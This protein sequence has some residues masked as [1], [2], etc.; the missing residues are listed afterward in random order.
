MGSWIV[1]LV[2]LSLMGSVFWVM[3]STRDRLRMRL[4]Q[5]A[6]AMGLKV[7]LPDQSL[8][9]RLIRYEDLI[10]GSMMYECLNFSHQAVKFSGGLYVLKGQDDS[11]AFVEE[12]IPFGIDK[13]MVLSAAQSLP[14]SCRL[15]VLTSNSAFVFWDERGDE[16]DVDMIQSEL[17]RVNMCLS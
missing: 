1:V 11:W 9:E 13:D 8:K 7:R 5:R 15:L 6:M 12:S 10:L 16:K 3:P 14:M 4:R 2:A 17:E